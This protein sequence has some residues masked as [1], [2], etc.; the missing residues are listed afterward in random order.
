MGALSINPEIKISLTLVPAE[1]KDLRNVKANIPQSDGSF[2]TK[3]EPRVNL[4]YWLR[5]FQTGE[6]EPKCYFLDENANPFELKTF[7]DAGNIY[8]HEEHKRR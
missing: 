6:I 8:I 4:P 3:Y 1:A 7:L 5:S 2:K